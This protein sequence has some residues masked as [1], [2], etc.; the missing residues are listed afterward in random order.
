MA[1]V[2]SAR[3][4]TPRFLGQ[5]EVAQATVGVMRNLS[6]TVDVFQRLASWFDRGSVGQ[7]PVRGTGGATSTTTSTQSTAG[8]TSWA[9]GKQRQERPKVGEN[10]DLA[11]MEGTIEPGGVTGG[12]SKS[13]DLVRD[14]WV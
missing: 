9:P 1:L 14:G 8:A 2:T 4:A 12:P 13:I 5:L 3:L 11:P 6:T 7:A 10:M